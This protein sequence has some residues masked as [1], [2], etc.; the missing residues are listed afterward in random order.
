MP[1]EARDAISSTLS[2]LA[3]VL[4]TDAP[5]R[6]SYGALFGVFAHYIIQ[7]IAYLLAV[8]WFVQWYECAVVGLG[9][10]NL[11]NFWR[12]M[13]GKP[14]FPERVEKKFAILRR[15]KAEGLSEA[16]YKMQLTQIV[17]D[18]IRDVDRHDDGGSSPDGDVK[19][20]KDDT[21]M[22]L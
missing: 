11:K 9:L 5:V 14:V 17:R 3:A 7:G 13:T 12:L 1:R 21:P 22:T 10:I 8:H 20:S 4:L 6:N 16:Q 19:E 18:S 2:W 15:A